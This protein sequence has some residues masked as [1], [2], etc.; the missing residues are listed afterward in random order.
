VDFISLL[1]LNVTKMYF[2]IFQENHK[3]IQQYIKNILI[4]V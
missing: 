3:M 1:N 4:A 2:I